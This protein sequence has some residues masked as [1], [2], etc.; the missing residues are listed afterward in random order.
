MIEHRTTDYYAQNMTTIRAALAKEWDFEPPW[1][2]A[3]STLHPTVYNDPEGEARIVWQSIGCGAPRAFGPDPIP[4]FSP[5][6]TAADWERG[7]IFPAS[8]SGERD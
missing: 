2:L 1:L 4:I 8:G 6:R 7:G 5:V 3:K